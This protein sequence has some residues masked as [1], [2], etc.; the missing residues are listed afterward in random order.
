[1]PIFGFGKKEKKERESRAKQMAEAGMLIGKSDEWEKRIERRSEFL[2]LIKSF[3]APSYLKDD[4]GKEMQTLAPP[5]EQIDYMLTQMTN[6]DKI[7]KETSVPY[8]T[9]GSENWYGEAM[10]GW[11]ELFALS[12][13]TCHTCAR[14]V[15]KTEKY[16]A[17]DILVKLRDFLIVEI[18]PWAQWIEDVSWYKT[19]KPTGYT[20]VLP[21]MPQQYGYPGIQPRPGSTW[22]PPAPG[23]GAEK[24]DDES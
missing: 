11:E 13:L 22:F 20:I 23:E 24:R 9:G 12:K 1:M 10:L 19:D 21:T 4:S 16:D 5:K 6:I 7:I 18:I 2:K 3:D 15:A 17:A 8:G 14:M